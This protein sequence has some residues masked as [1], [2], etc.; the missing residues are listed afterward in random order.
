MI[1]CSVIVN[2]ESIVVTIGG[3][4]VNE[5]HFGVIDGM[6]GW[7]D[8]MVMIGGGVMVSEESVVVMIGG[9]SRRRKC[10]GDDD[11]DSLM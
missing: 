3:A 8:T 6:S 1:G 9:V 5:E 4:M 11:D 2:E 7:N 10:Y